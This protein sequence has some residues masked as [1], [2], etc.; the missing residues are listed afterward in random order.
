MRG[1]IKLQSL[2]IGGADDDDDDF[3]SSTVKQ[4]LP[5]CGRERERERE[6]ESRPRARRK[7][8]ASLRSWVLTEMLASQSSEM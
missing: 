4:Y 5:I 6:R 1:H 2:N 8:S 7:E 3:I